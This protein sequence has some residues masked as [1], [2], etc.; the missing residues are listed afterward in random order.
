MS[1]CRHRSS[2]DNWR[3]V[4]Q[5]SITPVRHDF[6]RVTGNICF[7]RD[8]FRIIQGDDNQKISVCAEYGHRCLEFASIRQSTV[9]LLSIALGG[10]NFQGRKYKSINSIPDTGEFPESFIVGLAAFTSRTNVCA[11]S[12]DLGRMFGGDESEYFQDLLDIWLKKDQHVQL[13]EIMSE[14]DVTIYEAIIDDLRLYYLT[15]G[16]ANP[17]ICSDTFSGLAIEYKRHRVDLF[18]N[19]DSVPD[20]IKA[21]T[22]SFKE[23]S[24]ENWKSLNDNGPIQKVDGEI[25]VTL[26]CAPDQKAG[27]FDYIPTRRLTIRY[28]Q[29]AFLG[30]Q[31]RIERPLYLRYEFVSPYAYDRMGSYKVNPSFDSDLETSI[32]KI[33]NTTRRVKA[34]YECYYDILI[35]LIGFRP[36][37]EL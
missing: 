34:T 29:C 12:I 1:I 22:Q 4:D 18:A 19:L 35:K 20:R 32:A 3:W 7:K 28:E 37:M 17:A 16:T 21:L 9:Y 14:S 36:Y 10:L 25:S 30:H 11:Y 26:E 23:I 2:S 27:Y 24:L 5:H 6:G 33:M 8:D 13:K 31:S 15:D